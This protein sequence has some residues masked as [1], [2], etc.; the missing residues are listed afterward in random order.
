MGTSIEARRTCRHRPRSLKCNDI[1]SM[2]TQGPSTKSLICSV[3]SVTAS[4]CT[5]Y[6]VGAERAF[7]TLGCVRLIIEMVKFRETL[8]PRFQP[9]AI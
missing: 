4:S 1:K 6:C 3:Y 7:A 8:A 9:A 2:N 5:S